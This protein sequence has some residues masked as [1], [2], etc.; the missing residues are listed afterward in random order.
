MADL[1]SSKP[2]ATYSKLSPWKDLIF[3]AYFLHNRYVTEIAKY[4]HSTPE[5]VETVFN[6]HGIPRRNP[7]WTHPQYQEYRQRMCEILGLPVERAREFRYDNKE[8][9]QLRDQSIIEEYKAGRSLSHI[10]LFHGCS[11]MH[12]RKVLLSHGIQTRPRGRPRK[13]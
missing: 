9:R 1:A 4:L 10:G 6:T 7:H 11:P 8:L 13:P 3:E 2:V 12:A 5:A